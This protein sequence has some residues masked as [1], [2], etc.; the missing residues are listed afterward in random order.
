MRVVLLNPPMKTM[1]MFGVTIEAGASQPPL[2]LCYVAAAAFED[3]YDVL[4]LD[5]EALGLN[6]EA[7]IESIVDLKPDILGVTATTASVLTAG[8]IAKEVKKVCPNCIT[9]LGGCHVSALPEKTLERLPGIDVAVVGEGE[10][11]FKEVLRAVKNGNS[12][13]CVDG[14]VYRNHGLCQTTPRARVSNLDAL[15]MPA[16]GLLPDIESHYQVQFHSRLRTPSFSLVT[17]RG[18]GGECRF[19]PRVVFG[20]QVTTHSGDRTFEMVRCLRQQHGIRSILFDED[21]LLV[22]ESRVSRYSDL[23]IESGLDVDWACLTRVDSVSEELLKKIHKAGCWQLLFGIE[24]GSQRILDFIGKGITLESVRQAVQR[25]RDAGISSKGFFILGLPTET[26]DT[27]EETIEFMLDLPLDDMT[28]CFFTPFPGSDLGMT[29][30]AY[31][32]VLT[33]WNRL[34][35]YEPSFIP[36]DLTEDDL[37][38][39][40]QRCVKLFYSRGRIVHSYLDRT[41]NDE[42]A[43]DYACRF[44]S[45]L[46]GVELTGF[47]TA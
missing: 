35:L 12:F 29:A 32:K 11:T 14:V 44:L 38:E 21:N 5:A 6:S 45:E 9:V 40:G 46:A 27:I 24:S 47:Q 42:R 19:C 13:D 25:A 30:H 28:F 26:R 15:P 34:N 22:P 36:K 23:M 43:R 20:S 16:W 37:L 31:G 3:G 8:A 18:C 10:I 1:E 33:D 7:C 4:I 39:Y 17:S 41:A 2:G